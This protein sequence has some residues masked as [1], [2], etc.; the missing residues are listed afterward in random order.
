MCRA[1]LLGAERRN[2]RYAFFAFGLVAAVLTGARRPAVE[3]LPLFLLFERGL[4]VAATTDA[5][6]PICLGANQ[7]MGAERTTAA[8]TADENF[9]VKYL[10]V[11]LRRHAIKKPKFD[12][13]GGPAIKR[14]SPPLRT[15]SRTPLHA[16][17]GQAA[18][19]QASKVRLAAASIAT[20][21]ARHSGAIGLYLGKAIAP[22]GPLDNRLTTILADVKKTG[23]IKS[24]QGLTHTAGRVRAARARRSGA[25]QVDALVDPLHPR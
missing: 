2:R 17:L 21:E 24:G 25:D 16:Y 1:G 15:C 19:I 12:S 14:N 6:D 9:H 22:N 13:G 8:V 11:A 23:F 10:K 20:V 3:T 5:A 4:I 18:N 7:Q